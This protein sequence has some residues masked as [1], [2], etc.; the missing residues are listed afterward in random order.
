MPMSFVGM[1]VPCW[2]VPA[3]ER[4]HRDKRRREPARRDA[5]RFSSSFVGRRSM[6]TDH[7]TV[8]GATNRRDGT[9]VPT[10]NARAYAPPAEE[11]L[12]WL[13]T[14]PLRVG[15]LVFLSEEGLF[16]FFVARRV[17]LACRTRNQSVV[18]PV[19]DG[20]NTPAGGVQV[21][22]APMCGG[23]GSEQSWEA[24]FI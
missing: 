9:F 7:K 1:Y 8:V 21:S 24:A 3:K 4:I 11:P 10:S 20:W 23:I 15:Y 17:S 13:L 14:C 16:S 5:T 6:E 18:L 22:G 19:Q 2:S 12:E